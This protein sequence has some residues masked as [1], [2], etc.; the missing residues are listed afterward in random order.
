MVVHI[1]F[2]FGSEVLN[3][4]AILAAEGKLLESMEL[5][6]RQAWVYLFFPMAHYGSD[7]LAIAFWGLWLIPLGMLVYQSGL[8]SH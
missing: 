4:T 1:S 6:Q 7:G 2:E 3:Y 5:L 8:C